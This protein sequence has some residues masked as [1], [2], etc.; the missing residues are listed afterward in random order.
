TVAHH[1]RAVA[2]HI[3]QNR[4]DRAGHLGE[5]N[6]GVGDRRGD[7]DSPLANL[8]DA[9]RTTLRFP[10]GQEPPCKGLLRKPGSLDPIRQLRSNAVPLSLY[11]EN[12]MDL[13]WLADFVDL[14]ESGSFSRAAARR[15]V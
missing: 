14:T 7:R 10:A 12:D 9:H 3:G 8:D 5:I 6:E 15:D 1:R 13:S 4:D 11:A 2:R